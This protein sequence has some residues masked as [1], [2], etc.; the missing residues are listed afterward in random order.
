MQAR[1]ADNA[2]QQKYQQ[3]KAEVGKLEQETAEIRS[4]YEN[5][6]AGAVAEWCSYGLKATQQ[7]QILPEARERIKKYQAAENELTGFEKKSA[8]LNS[9]RQVTLQQKSD[10]AGRAQGYAAEENSETSRLNTLKEERAKQFGQKDTDTE[11]KALNEQV[12]QLRAASSEASG[13]A[14]TARTELKNLQARH[15]ELRQ[16]IGTRS[17]ELGKIRGEFSQKCAELGI[18]EQDYPSYLLP[19]QEIA[20]LSAKRAGLEATGA[21]I[22]A[23][24]KRLAEEIAAETGKLPPDRTEGSVKA[25]FEAKQAEKDELQKQIGALDRELA[26]NEQNKLR[27]QENLTAIR[28][29]KEVCNKWAD[30][31]N[32]IGQ[33]NAFQRLAQGIT[34]DNLLSRANTEL[35]GLYNRYKLIR[36]EKKQL[37]IDVLDGEQGDVIRPSENLSGGERFI[38]SLA[39][40]LGLSSMAGERIRIDSLFLDEGFG[41]LDS[42]SLQFIMHALG[43]LHRAGKLVGIISHV[44]MLAEEISCVLQVKQTGGGKSILSGPGITR[45]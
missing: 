9:V 18:A 40:A 8:E 14:I 16:E 19:A 24:E 22:A 15:E 41:T 27:S 11:E 13:K 37:G 30:L 45:L 28:H 12:T 1:I 33:G 6:L 3:I 36:S 20:Q 43:K 34:L 39:L 35:E 7:K 26:L 44:S 4:E 38:V 23:A 31:Y 17:I 42:E 32:M 5:K 2:A 29:Q 21:E 25:E 10:A